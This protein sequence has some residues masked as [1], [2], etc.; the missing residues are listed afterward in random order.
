MHGVRHQLGKGDEAV[1]Q[2]EDGGG[3]QLDVHGGADH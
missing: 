2:T 1:T 3:L